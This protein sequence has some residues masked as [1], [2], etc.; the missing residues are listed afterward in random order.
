MTHCLIGAPGSIGLYRPCND[1][2]VSSRGG[3]ISPSQLEDSDRASKKTPPGGRI[4]TE[5]DEDGEIKKR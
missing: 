1:L 5:R 3:V 4:D 2:K